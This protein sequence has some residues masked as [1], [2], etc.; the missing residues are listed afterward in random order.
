MKV[1]TRTLS[2]GNR[3]FTLF[4]LAV[5]LFIIGLSLAVVAVSAGR[6]HEKSV[7]QEEARRIYLTLQHGRSAALMERKEIV[8]RINGETGSYWLDDEG[9]ARNRHAVPGRFVLTGAEVIFFPKGNSTGGAIGLS[10]EK[11]TRYEIAV[12]PVLGTSRIKRL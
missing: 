1:R 9:T 5:V 12:D 4:E 8:F 7:F 11:G 3:G 6:L 2:A 10:D